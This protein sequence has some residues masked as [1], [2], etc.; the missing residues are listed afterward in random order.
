MTYASIHRWYAGPWRTKFIVYC[1]K[2]RA[3]LGFLLKRYL[4]SFRVLWLTWGPSLFQPAKQVAVEYLNTGIAFVF[5]LAFLVDTL[6]SFRSY[7][8]IQW[9]LEKANQRTNTQTFWIRVNSGRTRAESWSPQNELF[10]PSPSSSGNFQSRR[11]FCYKHKNV[12]SVQYDGDSSPHKGM[13]RSN[14]PWK[15]TFVIVHV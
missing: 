12:A 3:L 4:N 9:F 11:R 7:Q 5:Y 1:E 6:Y 2:H 10:R 14:A 15:C 13:A 8:T